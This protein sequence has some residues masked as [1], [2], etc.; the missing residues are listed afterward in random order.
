MLANLEEEK[1]LA[2][3]FARIIT[4]GSKHFHKCIF[5]RNLQVS[6]LKYFFSKKNFTLEQNVAGHCAQHKQ[7][8]I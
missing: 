2:R 8:I 6:A 1:I 3:I 5:Y 7:M 4:T